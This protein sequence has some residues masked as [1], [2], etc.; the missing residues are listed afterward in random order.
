MSEGTQLFCI[1]KDAQ[2]LERGADP[3]SGC[4]YLSDDAGTE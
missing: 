4:P 2:R 3:Q 1:E